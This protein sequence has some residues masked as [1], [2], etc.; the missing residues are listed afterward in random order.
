MCFHDTF[1]D[2]QPQPGASGKADALPEEVR[3]P[4]GRDPPS[5]V[6]DRDR[7]VRAVARRLHPDRR[8]LRGVPPRVGEEID[9][10]LYDALGVGHRPRKVRRKVDEDR[11]PASAAQERGPGLVHQRG[12]VGGL[13]CDGERARLD[14]SRV[15]QVRDEAPHVVGLA[16]DEAKELQHLGP[17]RDRRGLEHG[18]GR[19]LDGGE[20]G[21]QFVAHHAQEV[22]PL[23][24]QFVERRQILQRDD[25]RDHLSRLGMDRGR[26]DERP[27]APAVGHR[28]LDLF[29]ARRRGALELPGQ[30]ELRE[31]V[32]PPVGVP[33]GHHLQ[34][35]LRRTAR[36]ADLLADPLRF[37]VQR[38]HTPRLCVEHR[39]AH[40][41][42]FHQ[43]LQV[44]AGPLD[45]AV[46]AGIRD[47]R[48]R[49]R[50][51]EGENLLV[52]SRERLA[53][54]LLP[55]EEVT[56]MLAP[57]V[58]RRSLNRPRNPRRRVEAARPEVTGE[59]RKPKWLQ[60]VPKMLEEP[61]PVGPRRHRPLLV[62]SEAGGQEVPKLPLLVA[63]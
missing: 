17:G 45:V 59:V 15:Q 46:G 10:H 21:A 49:L 57:V 50:G 54:A 36:G 47:R 58:H 60:M 41:R 33:A 7:E 24:L 1:A 26:V 44:G 25:D 56:E 11:V 23:P 6:R 55:E 63:S 43:G 18:R 51:E 27:H 61:Q 12:H 52:F 16:V 39:H 32:L 35:L 2:R 4:L 5:L 13:G 20:R 37:P 22:R 28:E 40:R 19:T 62:E 30:R 14:A 42:G 8:R 53:V 31:R 3:E 38:H 48:G 29:G 34:K 9:E